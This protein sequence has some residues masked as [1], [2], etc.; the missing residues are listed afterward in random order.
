VERGIRQ[1]PLRGWQS[2]EFGRRLALK[3]LGA[4]T[5][6]GGVAALE[7]SSPAG[8]A[9]KVPT[10]K[11]GYVTPATGPLADFAVPDR[12]VL[13]LVRSTGPFAKGI[14]IGSTRYDV[15][16]FVKD[17]RSDPA[18]AALVATELIQLNG[19]DIIVTSSPA[20]TTIPVSVLC[21]GAGVPCLST[22]C[23]WETWWG[24][25][26]GNSI[27]TL[28]NAVG[29]TP[30][31]C[32]MFF[33]GIEQYVQ[34]F[35]P[36]WERILGR[37]GASP[38]Y[39]GMFP[40]DL[41]G[42]AFRATWP[43][44]FERFVK[45][46]T[47]WTYVDGGAYTDLTGDFT[48]MVSSFLSGSNGKPCDFFVDCALPRDFDTLWRAASQQ[49]WR[50]KLATAAR[51]AT[52]P[53]DVYGLEGLVNNVAIDGWFTPNAPYRS[54]LDGLT[55]HSFAAQY[56]STTNQQW[57]QSL[58]STYALFEV[59]IEALKKVSNPHDRA[60]VAAALKDVRYD[61]M[62][63]PLD[64]AAP[65][66]PAKGVALLAPVGL[67]W[68]PG[69]SELVGHRRFAWSPW[70]VDNTLNR[71]IPLQASLEPTNA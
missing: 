50:P 43:S 39:A 32:S 64:F 44:T 45:K 57:V 35:A 65:T 53:N 15:E 67:Q 13:N 11:I 29:T 16:I 30:E 48:S 1:R 70:V 17:S 5:W 36:M 28:G 21:E 58:G 33:Y 10:I 68:K 18:T 54:S 61:G 59:V 19:V 62:L 23:P 7:R 3:A 49:G 6:A 4:A 63:G 25:F 2:A 52:F 42:A 71:D 31:F 56:Q 12:F 69:S 41:E 34:C 55:A 46:V 51:G 47:P 22:V 20:E 37:T 14:M 9:D 8:A 60:A 40:S 26:A 66:N 24:G 38:V 27:G